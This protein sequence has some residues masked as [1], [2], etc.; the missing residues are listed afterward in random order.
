M[1]EGIDGK[2]SRI[3]E[4]SRFEFDIHGHREVAYAYI[5]D[6]IDEDVVLEK[7]WIDHRNV[8][9]APAKKSLF[10]HSKG[11]RVRCNEGVVTK[12]VAS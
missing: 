4:V 5:I 7:G 9:I 2:L 1:I 6:Y 8:T 12:S 10:I 3:E 11:L